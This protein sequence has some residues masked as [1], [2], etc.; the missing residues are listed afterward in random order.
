MRGAL[1]ILKSDVVRSG[2]IRNKPRVSNAG[3]M[4]F[5]DPE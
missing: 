1:I 3:L 4:F 2:A 5:S